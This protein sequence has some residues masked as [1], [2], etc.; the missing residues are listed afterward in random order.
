MTTRLSKLRPAV[1]GLAFGLTLASCAVTRAPTASTSPAAH[2]TAPWLYADLYL[3]TAAE[4]EAICLQTYN[5]AAERLKAKIAALPKV[6]RIPA[7]VMD[8]DETVIDNGGYQSFLHREGLTNSSA[9]WEIWE[10]DH[11]HEVLLVPGAKGFI[12]TAESLGAAVVYISNRTATFQ[13]YTVATLKNLGLSLVGI[14]RRLLLRDGPSDKTG[15]RK[16]ADETFRVVM[17]V[18]DNLRDF[19][20]AFAVPEPYG[21]EAERFRALEDRKDKVRENASRW[22]DDWIVLPNPVYGEWTK[23]IASDPRKFL[24]PTA[25]KK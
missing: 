11:F 3:Q 20:D 19:S 4:Y 8:L 22:G 17:W 16:K 5:W 13:E 7:V 23:P 24:R 1:L 6:G 12:E 18:G 15:R 9:L 2:P 14:D 10:K 25:M 21:T